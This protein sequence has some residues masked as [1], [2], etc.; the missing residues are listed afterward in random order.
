M[1]NKQ[2]GSRE[3]AGRKKKS[4]MAFTV[5]CHPGVIDKVREYAEEESNKIINRYHE[6]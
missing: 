6:N 4:N 5:R 1:K 2:G 3:G